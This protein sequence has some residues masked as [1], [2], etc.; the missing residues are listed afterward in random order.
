MTQPSIDVCNDQEL[1]MCY[2]NSH[3]LRKTGLFHATM[4]PHLTRPSADDEQFPAIP[5]LVVN[6]EP[7]R[8]PRMVQSLTERNCKLGTFHTSWVRTTGFWV[9]RFRVRR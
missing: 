2:A 4:L 7:V 3:L 1:D 6:N 5:L 8:D 9:S